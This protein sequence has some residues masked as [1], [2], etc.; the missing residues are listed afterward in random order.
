MTAPGTTPPPSTRSNSATPVLRLRI[1]SSGTSRIGL[2][3]REA[4]TCAGCTRPTCALRLDDGSPA[5][6]L[7]APP[8]PLGGAPAAFAAAVPLRSRLRAGGGHGSNVRAS[9]DT[10]SGRE[11][12]VPR[13]GSAAV[14]R[15]R[16]PARPADRRRTCTPSVRRHASPR[17]RTGRAASRTLVGG[18][19]SERPKEH[20]SKTCVGVT[21]PW[22]QIPP[23][24][25][26]RGPLHPHE[27]ADREALSGWTARPSTTSRP[28]SSWPRRSSGRSVT[29]LRSSSKRSL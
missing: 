2:G 17:T 5:L 26:T 4:G 28:R 25:P 14:C 18:G 15:S 22:V 6:A 24:P 29:G 1:A 3:R 23:P 19:V 8:D 27:R 16:S 12:W 9:T 7:A 21:P 20:V 10:V 13:A 11:A